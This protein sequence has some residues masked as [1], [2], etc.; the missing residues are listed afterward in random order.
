MGVEK[1]NPKMEGT[2]LW[3]CRPQVG[4]CPN[5]CNQCFYNRPNAFYCDINQPYIPDPEQ[6]GNGIVRINSG[7]DSNIQR[8]LVLETASKYNRVFYNTSIPNF[9]FPGPV[10]FT[11]NAKEEEPAWCPIVHYQYKTRQIP[12]RQDQ[13]FDRL[14]FVRLRVSGTNLE[15]I[16]HAVAAWTSKDIPVVLTFMAYY[17]QDPPGCFCISDGQFGWKPNNSPDGQCYALIAYQWKVRHINSYYCPTKD[18]VLYV[19]NRMRKFGGRLVTM[20]GTPDSGKCKDCRN[21]ETYYIQRA[22][23]LAERV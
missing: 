2:N 23:Y 9:D 18:F 6:V 7:H 19:L 11:A 14:M 3:D 10:V 5:G 12:P 22:K 4:L 13:F 15:L 17:D 8:D 1:L 20:C 21:C 16:E